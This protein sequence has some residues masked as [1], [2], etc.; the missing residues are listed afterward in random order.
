MKLRA[1]LKRNHKLVRHKDKSLKGQENIYKAKMEIL[2][3]VQE[4]DKV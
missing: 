1:D 2:P 3:P 4:N